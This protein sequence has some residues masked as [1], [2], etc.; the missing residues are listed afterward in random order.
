MVQALLLYTTVGCHLCEQAEEVLRVV[1]ADASAPNWTPVEISNDPAL[2]EAYGL[3]IPVIRLQGQDED[4]GWP[5]DD[6][7]VRQYLARMSN[8]DPD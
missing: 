2:V 3:R 1:A 4:L 7:A 8:Q 6:I 5:F